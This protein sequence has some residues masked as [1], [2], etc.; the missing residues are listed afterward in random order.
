MIADCLRSEDNGRRLLILY[1]A[2]DSDIRQE[3]VVAELGHEL[4]TSI[5]VS[6]YLQE[7]QSGLDL[8]DDE[9]MIMD[10]DPIKSPEAVKL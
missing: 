5:E 3:S 2:D 6:S 1:N 7:S 10:I 9:A 8:T 4:R